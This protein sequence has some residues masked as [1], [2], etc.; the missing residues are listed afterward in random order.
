MG[1]QHLSTYDWTGVTLS[2]GS[3]ERVAQSAN[4]DMAV[5]AGAEDDEGDDEDAYLCGAR[6]FC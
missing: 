5:A 1:S 3:S 2:S 4:A 6:R